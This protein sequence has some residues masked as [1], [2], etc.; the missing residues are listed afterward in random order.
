[1]A[2]PKDLR[3]R[4]INLM[5]LVLMAMLA[6]NIDPS[7]LQGY[8][9]INDGMGDSFKAFKV[10]NEATLGAIKAKAEKEKKEEQIDFLAKA[11]QLSGISTG[12]DG[13]IGSTIS[14]VKDLANGSIDSKDPA[15]VLMISKDLKTGKAA[16][17]KQQ[18]KETIEKY[19]GIVNDSKLSDAQKARLVDNF[20]LKLPTDERAQADPENKDKL[21]WEEWT[22]KGKPAIAVEA[23]LNQFKNDAKATEGQILDAFALAQDIDEKVIDIPSVKFDV[24]NLAVMP[25]STVVEQGKP[26]KAKLTVGQSSTSQQNV[27]K[28]FHNGRQLTMGQDGFASFTGSPKPIGE[29][30]ITGLYAEVYDPNTKKTKK[31][32]IKSPVKYRVVKKIDK[33]MVAVPDKK[34]DK[35]ATVSAEKMNVFYAGLTNPV[36]VAASGLGGVSATCTGCSSFAADGKGGYNAKVPASLIG[37]TVNV[38]VTIGGQQAGSKKFR[39]MRVPDPT[40]KLGVKKSGQVFSTGELG[41]QSFVQADLENFVF[42]AKFKVQ[43]Y[44]MW[45]LTAKGNKRVSGSGPQLTAE[46][47]NYLSRVRPGARIIVNNMKAKGPDGKVRTIAPAIYA[48]R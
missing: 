19:K 45:F 27:I 18:I 44:D 36:A 22:F 46:M 15:D 7:A 29:H 34:L 28:I 11:E 41:A 31:V 20:S 39:V 5:Y 32:S 40:T 21:G 16:Q 42:N 9:T 26:F 17:L 33:N 38:N 12:L 48:V 25:E 1:M 6:I 47:K 35:R 2:F 14:E 43:S 8:K 30:S 13:F 4:M 37:K 23:M 10:K 3:Q 24:F